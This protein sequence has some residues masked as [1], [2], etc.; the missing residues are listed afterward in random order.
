MDRLLDRVDPPDAVFCF[1]DPL[2]LGALRA[3]LARGIRVPDDVAIIGFDDIEDGAF[4]TPT[5]ST[6]TPDRQFIARVALDRIEQK[7]DGTQQPEPKLTIAPHHL[8]IRE[9]STS[10]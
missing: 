1:S 4:S 5:L 2:A 7:L 3:L 6:V 9:S 8:T 10:A